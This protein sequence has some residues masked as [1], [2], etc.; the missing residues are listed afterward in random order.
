MTSPE[1][2]KHADIHADND[3]GFDT[4]FQFKCLD[5]IKYFIFDLNIKKTAY[6]EESLTRYPNK[7]V[8]N[9]FEMRDLNS[10]LNKNLDSNKIHVKKPKV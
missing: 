10:E 9:Y 2:E 7:V 5:I 3:V 6:I 1:L 8:S 4:A